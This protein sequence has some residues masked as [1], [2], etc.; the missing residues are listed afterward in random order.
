MKP[1]ALIE[2]ASG[3]FLSWGFAEFQYD[4]TKETVLEDVP[5]PDGPDGP[6]TERSAGTQRHKWDGS[7]WIIVDKELSVVQAAWLKALGAE[8]TAFIEAR[9]SVPV[10]S[11]MTLLMTEATSKGWAA[12]TTEVQK[13]IT[14]L[15]QCLDE[16]YDK[17][18][19]VLAAT[20]VAE[21]E[22]IALD[23]ATLD[24]DDPKVDLETIRGLTS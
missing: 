24:A 5:L 19:E 3:Y 15:S 11:S 7:K 1:R 6:L 23:T 17:K 12:R 18:A 21:V 16:Y 14:W 22:A 13:G 9:Y 10:Q 8:I 4:P 20:T 2:T